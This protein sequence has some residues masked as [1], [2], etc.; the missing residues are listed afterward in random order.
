MG[1][2]VGIV[3]HTSPLLEQQLGHLH[4]VQRRALFDLVA[5][6]KELQPLVSWLAYVTAHAADVHVVVEGGVQGGGEAVVSA[7]VDDLNAGCL[8]QH[9]QRRLLAHFVVKLQVYALRMRA[10]HRDADAGGRDTNIL[11]APDLLGLL[12]HLHLLLVVPVLHHG[13]VMREQ[14]EGILK[15]E[16]VH[17]DG[18][19]VKHLARLQHKLIHG[20]GTSARSRLVGGDNHPLD[21]AHLVQRRD[22]HEGDD[23]GAVGVGN[24]ATLPL[25]VLHPRHR[26]WVDLRNHQ[27]HPLCHPK[28]GA[29]VHHHRPRINRRR[30]KLLADTAASAEQRNVHILEAVHCELLHRVGLAVKVDLLPCRPC[31]G[32]HLHVAVREVPL[33]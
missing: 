11:V 4:R 24:D 30:P 32:E 16:D 15:G 20:S 31:T 23:G 9:L 7:V 6:H 25:T 17:G 12:H 2:G 13:R 27:R 22:G 1:V 5:A 14:I 28:R 26:V 19:V 33:F 18:F 8:A 10:H 3:G 29:V 21:G